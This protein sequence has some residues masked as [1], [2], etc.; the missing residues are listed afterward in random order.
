MSNEAINIIEEYIL[1]GE[2]KGETYLTLLASK[3]FGKLVKYLFQE[4]IVKQLIL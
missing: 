3:D 1:H 2:Q 4:C